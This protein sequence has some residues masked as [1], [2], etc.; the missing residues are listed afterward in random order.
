MNLALVNRDFGRGAGTA[1]YAVGLA[2]WL[3]QQGH[4]VTVF[5]SRVR[6]GLPDGVTLRRLPPVRGGTRGALLDLRPRE[7]VGA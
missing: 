7:G 4:T 2:G 6:G 5:A 3:A 1:G